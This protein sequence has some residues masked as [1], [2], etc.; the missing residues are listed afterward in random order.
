MR[1]EPVEVRVHAALDRLA[2]GRPALGIALSG[3]GDSTALLHLA[4]GWGH[5]RLLAAT[6][7]HGL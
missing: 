1:A 7:D 6:V 4:H 3:G 5:A 2:A